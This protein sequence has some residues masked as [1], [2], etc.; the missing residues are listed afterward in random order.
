MFSEG[1]NNSQ[2]EN[3]FYLTKNAYVISKN[4]LHFSP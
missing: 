3:D 1:K 2:P 4:D